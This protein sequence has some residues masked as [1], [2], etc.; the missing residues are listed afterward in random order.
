VDTKELE[1]E[2]NGSEPHTGGAGHNE[3]RHT[4]SHA[5]TLSLLASSGEPLEQGE[6]ERENPE[7][8]QWTEPNQSESPQRL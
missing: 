4:G 2:K 7:G 3:D 8:G 1:H 6:Q 5:V